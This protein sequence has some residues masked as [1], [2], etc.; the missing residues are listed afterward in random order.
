MNLTHSV[1]EANAKLCEIGA[2]LQAGDFT[3]SVFLV[4]RDSV[5][6]YDNALAKRYG[7]WV[8]IWTEHHGY[9]VQHEDEL[10]SFRLIEKGRRFGD[11]DAIR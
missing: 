1:R 10:V 11:L 4:T 6:I 3:G 5:Q 2:T 7:E 8:L 9:H